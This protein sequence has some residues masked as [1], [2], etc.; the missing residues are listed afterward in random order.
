[1][2]MKKKRLLVFHPTIAPYR[3]DLFND[4]SRNF[5]ARICLLRRGLLTQ[6]FNYDWISAQFRFTP[7]Y[8]GTGLWAQIFFFLHN[9][10]DF[11]PE[12]VLVHEF[13]LGA[14]LV[15]LWRWMSR[16]KYKVVSFCDDSYDMVANHHD[17]SRKH[18]WA[19]RLLAP[20]VDDLILVEPN[21]RDWYQSRYGKGYCFPIIRDEE[22]L[23]ELYK[24]VLPIS[25]SY[26]ERY[27]LSGKK[28]FLFVGRL[29]KLKNVNFLM[30]AFAAAKISQARLV[31]VGSG[32]EA[33]ALQQLAEEMHI[34]VLF[35][36]R[37][38]GEQ[39]YA[40]YNAADCFVLPSVQESFGAVTNEALI[41]GCKCLVSELAGSQCLVE[42]GENG[43]TFN[44]H[45]Q[46]DLTEK[47]QKI[48]DELP[49]HTL[50]C[51]R[52]SVMTYKY[53]DCIG[54]LSEHIV[55]LSR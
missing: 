33:A 28:V 8:A 41:G 50:A 40:W 32:E 9:V 4:L 24:E 16:G 53:A 38:E 11:R 27:D 51:V 25:Q 6:K 30:R 31:I 49:E 15:L 23:R 34:D 46:A 3:V 52:P 48:S 35:T 42:K 45:D 37:L 29:V 13:G 55:N 36:G 26:V 54:C 39:L 17:F 5:D 10:R 18:R 2:C 21:V 19:R 1:M 44:P 43:Y 14:M 7:K 47:L 20:C 22:S 12:I